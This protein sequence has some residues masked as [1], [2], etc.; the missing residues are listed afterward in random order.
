[1]AMNSRLIQSLG[2]TA[3]LLV[4]MLA[5]T[6]C[7]TRASSHGGWRPL[8]E[9]KSTAGWEMLGPGELR[10]EDG[11]LVTYGG[12]GLLWYNKEKFGNCRI[13]VMFKP[14]TGQDNSGVFVRIPEPPP[15]PMFAVHRGYEVQIDNRG[16]EWRRTG[17]LYTVSLEKKKVNAR[18]NEWNTM[19]ITLEGLRTS[20]EINGALVTDYTE[21]E[22]VPPKGENDPARG[23][24]PE[25]G[26]IGLQN[27]D[28][29]SRVHFREVSVAPLRSR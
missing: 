29:N 24:R 7:R 26:Y 21:G 28:E 11:E 12:M 13:R 2:A 17:C 9:G 25:V 22:P 6:S 8:F 23:P 5:A 19:I 18:V 4:I 15:D 1:M 3:L 27:H 16:D 20:V 14:T 10:L